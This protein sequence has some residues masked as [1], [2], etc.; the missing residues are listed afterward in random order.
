MVGHNMESYRS[1]LM[2][3]ITWN[4]T[5]LSKVGYNMESYR[6]FLMWVITWNVTVL[7]QG[8]S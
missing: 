3:V 2:W 1:F 8:G 7:F 6:S 4:V 5:L